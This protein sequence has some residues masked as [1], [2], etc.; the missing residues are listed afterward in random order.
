M[1]GASLVIDGEKVTLDVSA[2]TIRQ[3]QEASR[4][5]PQRGSRPAHPS[6]EDQLARIRVIDKYVKAQDVLVD[7]VAYSEGLAALFATRDDVIHDLYYTMLKAQQPSDEE[8]AHLTV[9]TR[10]SA[11][12]E[13][14]RRKKSGS[15]WAETGTNC[16]K[17]HELNLCGRRGCDGTEKK[18]PV[19]HDAKL[20]LHR[21]PVLS[22][23]AEVEN[24]LQV[25]YWTHALVSSGGSYSWRPHCLPQ[26]GGLFSQEAWLIGALSALRRVHNELLQDEQ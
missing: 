2:M 13:M 11:W 4:Y 10:F 16:Y 19:W 5:R 3:Y 7:G 23:T 21:C 20:I 1:R 6:E 18:R 17:C 15:R 12:L 14:S 25:F 24:T 8:L 26:P 9:A 22:F